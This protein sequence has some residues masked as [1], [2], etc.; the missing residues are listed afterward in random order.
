MQESTTRYVFDSTRSQYDDL[1][2]IAIEIFIFVK[3]IPS[4]LIDLYLTSVDLA[5]FDRL[6]TETEKI[7]LFLTNCNH[8][9]YLC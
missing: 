2:N 5:S 1:C 4:E 9:G 8:Q 6:I 7:V 3:E